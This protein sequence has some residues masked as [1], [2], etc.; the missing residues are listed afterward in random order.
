MGNVR[1][2]FSP[3]S[4]K[5]SDLKDKEFRDNVL[6]QVE[7]LKLTTPSSAMLQIKTDHNSISLSAG[8][9]GGVVVSKSA[10]TLKGVSAGAVIRRKAIFRSEAVVDGVVF[11]NVVVNP[12]NSAELVELSSTAEVIFIGCRFR[13]TTTSTTTFIKAASGAKA[14]FIGCVF[15]GGPGSG[16]VFDHSGD[17]ANIILIGCRNETVSATFGTIQGDTEQMLSG[18]VTIGAAATS[19]TLSVGAAYTGKPVLVTA[20]GFPTMPQPKPLTG[21]VAGGTLTVSCSVAPGVGGLKVYYMI[22]GR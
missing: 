2:F 1:E 22:D 9:H 13:K 6:A 17:A 7:S 19:V 3:S 21:V 8:E 18:H 16:T 4:L 5:V 12:T 15:E 10:S 14:I 20:A 11:S